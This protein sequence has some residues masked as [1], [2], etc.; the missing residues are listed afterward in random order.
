MLARGQNPKWQPNSV[1][2]AKYGKKPW[3]PSSVVH[4]RGG[5]V[6]ICL[7]G[8]NEYGEVPRQSVKRYGE[9][10]EKYSRRCTTTSRVNLHI[11]EYGGT[12]YFVQYSYRAKLYLCTWCLVLAQVRVWVKIFYHSQARDRRRRCWDFISTEHFTDTV[13]RTST[14][15]AKMENLVHFAFLLDGSS[16]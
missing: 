6:K 15:H 11:Y 8:V 1:V 16:F 2:W 14:A 12:V 9:R 5:E 4:D 3:W 13:L 10:F 7:L